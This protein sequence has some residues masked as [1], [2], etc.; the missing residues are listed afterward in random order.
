VTT[1]SGTGESEREKCNLKRGGE[2]KKRREPER[3][4]G[5][6]IRERFEECVVRN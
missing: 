6:R 2:V 3:V 5:E 1:R 4:R